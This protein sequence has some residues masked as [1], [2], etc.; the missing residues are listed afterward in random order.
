MKSS[1]IAR[2][3]FIAA[4]HT[5]QGIPSSADYSVPKTLDTVACS[6]PDGQPL[7]P[8]T[9]LTTTT[10][11]LSQRVQPISCGHAHRDPNLLLTTRFQRVA[12]TVCTAFTS[13][14]D[15][16]QRKPFNHRSNP[17]VALFECITLEGIRF[18]TRYADINILL[19]SH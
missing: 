16:W 9:L 10:L 15:R 6:P 3:N 13:V 18:V 8:H 11:T 14:A 1:A 5:Y 12:R 7:Q 4:A 2:V 19:T 17:L